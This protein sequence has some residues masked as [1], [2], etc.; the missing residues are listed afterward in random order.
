WCRVS[1]L[2]GQPH[3]K[4]EGASLTQRTLYADLPSHPFHELFANGKAQSGAAKLARGRSV[5]LGKGLEQK[6]LYLGGN[7]DPRV[8]H[9]KFDQSATSALLAP[10][11]MNHHF[12]LWGKLER[13]A[14][15]IEKDL[16][17]A[18]GVSPYSSGHFR[19]QETAQ[20]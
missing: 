12:A 17:Q 9:G 16:T 11:D 13:I 5:R 1:L 3:R 20:F 7:A 10:C 6:P 18:A 14:D 2:L 15:K 8:D 19:M 4:P